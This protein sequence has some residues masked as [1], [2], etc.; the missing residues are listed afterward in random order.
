MKEYGQIKGELE[1]LKFVAEQ[2][3]QKTLA[4][5]WLE[6]KIDVA[7]GYDK[8]QARELIALLRKIERRQKKLNEDRERSAT[9]A[10]IKALQEV[11]K[12]KIKQLGLGGKNEFN[13]NNLD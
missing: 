5:S 8:G 6:I 11:L 10:M 3:I 2:K 9:L 12:G 4:R 13:S 7:T 1:Y